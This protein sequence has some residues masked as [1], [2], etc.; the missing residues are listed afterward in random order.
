MPPF[1]FRSYWTWCILAVLIAC[2][3]TL[4]VAEKLWVRVSA[5]RSCMKGPPLNGLST[6]GMGTS[7]RSRNV[8]EALHVYVFGLE[9]ERSTNERI[10]AIPRHHIVVQSLY[11]RPVVVVHAPRRQRASTLLR[12]CVWCYRNGN[13]CRGHTC[14]SCAV[15]WCT[16]S[17]SIAVR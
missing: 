14:L 5:P 6:V 11:L 13:G 10:Y 15:H 7:I 16:K 12:W 1:T 17:I 2:S 4:G 3:Q 9:R 8:N